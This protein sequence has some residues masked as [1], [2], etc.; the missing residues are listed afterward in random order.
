MPPQPLLDLSA[1]DPSKVIVSRDEVYA[2]NPHRYE[3]AL[4]D[5]LL[6]L[7]FDA[8]E[9]AAVV[10]LTEQDFWV[11][12]HIPGRP[13][14]PGVLMIESAAQMVSYYVKAATR[15]E[16]FVGFGGVD[17][18]KFRGQVVPGDQLLLVGRMT[19]LRGT[20]RAIANTQGFVRSDMVFQGEITG[21][22][23]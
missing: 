7:D 14:F 1:L 9:M 23:L 4:L 2:V 12:G 13:L 17:G 18:V 5:G 11:R 16:G 21:M 10:N 8:Q 22:L 3:F 15:T 6:H 20:R 19:E